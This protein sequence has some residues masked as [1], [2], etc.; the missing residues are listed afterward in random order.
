VFYSNRLDRKLRNRLSAVARKADAF[1]EQGIVAWAQRAAEDAQ[2][3][4][5]LRDRD[6]AALERLEDTFNGEFYSGDGARSASP[7]YA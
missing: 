5:R 6:V 7:I 4:G 2:M 1:G 3:L